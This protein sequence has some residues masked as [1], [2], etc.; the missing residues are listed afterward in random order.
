M[1][2]SPLISRVRKKMLVHGNCLCLCVS[3]SQWTLAILALWIFSPED[4]WMSGQESWPFYPIKAVCVCVRACVCVCVCVCVC[5]HARMC[6]VV[7]NSLR[8]HGCSLPGSA[9]HGIFQAR[10]LEWVAMPSSRSSSQHRDRIHISWVSCIGRQILY[11]SCHLGS[12]NAGNKHLK[13]YFL[14]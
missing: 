13:D 1:K 11:H 3:I 7:S 8:P 5:A 9:V 2:T 4:R 12:P 10:V 14:V 6:S